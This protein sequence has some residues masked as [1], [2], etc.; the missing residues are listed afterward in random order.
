MTR[1]YTGVR[2]LFLT[3]VG[4]VL[5]GCGASRP[6][7]E[8]EAV[9]VD[10][11]ATG[12]TRALYNN[13]RDVAQDHLLFGHQ[14]DLAYGVT[15]KR[16]PGRSDVRDV[17][18]SYPAV[19][20]WELGDLEHGVAE[21]LDGVNFEDMKRWIQE[22]RRRGGVVTLSWHMDNPVTEG[23]SWD[24]TRAV[25]TILPGAENHEKYRQWLDRFADFVSDIEVGSFRWLGFGRPVPII[26]RPFHEHTGSWFWWGGD[27]VTP[28]EYKALWRFTVDYLRDEKNLHNLIY[29]YSTDVFD[30]EEEYF[31]FYPGDAYVDVLGVDDY[32]SL[33]RE[34]T[35]GEL[36]R[37]LRM[38]VRFADVRG[39]IAAFTETGAAGIPYERWWTD[40]LLAAIED[41]PLARRVAWVLVWRNANEED[42]ADHYFAPYPGHPSAP[43][44]IEFYNDPFV[45]FEDELPNL[46]R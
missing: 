11:H 16:E 1:T 38:L 31:R 43:N 27:N 29:A 8:T 44:F 24:T 42:F 13:L 32:H 37:R 21:N 18:G 22:G 34:E 39:K 19:Y 20:G 10:P 5:A 9:L 4:L 2:L 30:T 35:M 6:A 33:G 14:D 17:T 40:R 3:L 23:S 15:W 26:F 7:I 28:D 46:Y 12:E 41:D 36:T 25:H 45:L